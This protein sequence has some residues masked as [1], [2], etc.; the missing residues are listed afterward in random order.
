MTERLV[1][2]SCQSAASRRALPFSPNQSDHS[3]IPDPQ[4]GRFAI[5]TNVGWDAMDAIDQETNDFIADGEIVWSWRPDAGVKFAKTRT[6]S[7]G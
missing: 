3:R 5:V 7:C 6:A 4:E 1:C 2:P